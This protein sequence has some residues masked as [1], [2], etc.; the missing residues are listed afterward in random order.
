MRTRSWLF[1]AA[2]LGLAAGAAAYA[3]LV[4]PRWIQVRRPRIHIRRLP[5]ALEGLRIGLLTDLHAGPTPLPVILKAVRMLQQ[6]QPDLIAVTGDF[7]DDR[8]RYFDDVVAA[9]AELRAP[10]G[11][12]VV[13][14]NHDHYLGIRRWRGAVAR[15]R[16]LVDMT[17]RSLLLDID[18]ARL[19]VA[20]V[21]DMYQGQPRLHLPP[22]A[23]RDLTILLA[24]SPDQ[25]EHARRGYDRVDLVVC[26]H[27]HAGQ[28]RLPWIGAPVSS[29]T[30][31]DLYDEGLRRRPWTQVYT[32]R[33]VGTVRLPVRFLARPEIAVLHL[34]CTPRDEWPRG[35]RLAPVNA[36]PRRVLSVMEDE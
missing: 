21:D 12:Y 5:A 31:A 11:V 9:I 28:V 10:L 32:S 35:A 19:C 2:A 7:S 4:E 36:R 27:T 17:N 29:A 25:A 14:G 1:P 6:E 15:H 26:G 18:G 13:P 34:T 16:R 23:E 33:G 3:V 8:I 24:H 22:P 20:G 30:R